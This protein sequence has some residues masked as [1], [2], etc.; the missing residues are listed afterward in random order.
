MLEEQDFLGDAEGWGKVLA[1]IPD[2]TLR[3]SL[4]TLMPQC[5]SSKQ[6]WSTIQSE[7]SKAV[8]KVS[9][10]N[11]FYYSVVLRCYIAFGTNI[12]KVQYSI[13]SPCIQLKMVNEGQ[14]LIK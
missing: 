13:I 11:F 3:Q 2:Q 14:K 5:S 7:V 6:R 4:E 8:N 1:L 10:C 9:Q 12:K